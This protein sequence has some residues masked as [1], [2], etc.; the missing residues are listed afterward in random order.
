[1]FSLIDMIYF[2][3][4]SCEKQRAVIEDCMDTMT[5]I[6]SITCRMLSPN[7][8]KFALGLNE[9]TC[10]LLFVHKENVGSM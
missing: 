7:N 4:C 8:M 5:T 3:D 10:E 6:T 2:N 9:I 1:M